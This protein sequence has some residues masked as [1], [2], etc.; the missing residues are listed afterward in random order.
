MEAESFAFNV[1]VGAKL[2]T[3][4]SC[5]KAVILCKAPKRSKRLFWYLEVLIGVCRSNLKWGFGFFFARP[6]S[7]EMQRT[8][9]Q[10]GR[11]Q[12]ADLCDKV[13]HWGKGQEKHE[14]RNDNNMSQCEVVHL[15]KAY[16]YMYYIYYI[17]PEVKMG[18]CK[19]MNH[20][21]RVEFLP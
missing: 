2:S 19:M 20:K 13:Q 7:F 16:I 9:Q 14:N 15:A 8:L 21:K 6:N 4:R 12:G 5:F 3:A 17:Y 10:A 11:N 18:N 1:K